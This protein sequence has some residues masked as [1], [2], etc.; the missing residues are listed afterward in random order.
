[1]L[2]IL[3]C[4]IPA[5]CM[6]LI[7]VITVVMSIIAITYQ[8]RGLTK[9]LMRITELQEKQARESFFAEYTRR[10]QEIILNTP[11]DKNHPQWSRFVLLYF[12]LCS[13]EFHLNNK[14]LIDEHVWRLW[15]EGMKQMMKNPDY[16]M[17]WKTQSTKHYYNTDFVAFMHNIIIGK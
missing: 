13:E 17:A 12:D 15:Q 2:T 6:P 3:S 7:S 9:Q 16:R 14:G 5:E 1:M 10:Y 11:D 4:I 8:N